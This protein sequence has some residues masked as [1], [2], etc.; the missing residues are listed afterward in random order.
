MPSAR[1]IKQ[2]L[3]LVSRLQ[4]VSHILRFEITDT[5]AVLSNLRRDDSL[6]PLT[7]PARCLD[8]FRYTRRS[9]FTFERTIHERRAL[10]RDW[11]FRDGRH[12]S[13]GPI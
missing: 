10:R 11:G 5:E 8:D 4:T 12:H 1:L 2:F 6:P 3:I 13:D 9:S 7:D